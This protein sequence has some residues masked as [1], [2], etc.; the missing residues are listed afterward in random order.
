MS[1]NVTEQP[2]EALPVENQVNEFDDELEE[3]DPSM[4]DAYDIVFAQITDIMADGMVDESNVVWIIKAVM[5][6]IDAVA[7]FAEWPGPVK[8]Q[9][10]KLLAKHIIK[11]L[12]EKGKVDDET[13]KK[14]MSALSILSLAMFTLSVLGDKGKILFQHV[15]NGVQRA[16]IR[17]KNRQAEQLVQDKRIKK[18]RADLRNQAK[19]AHKAQCECGHHNEKKQ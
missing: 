16:C 7:V 11:D 10:S 18:G 14:L 15:K 2:M 12:H 13:Y 9:K 5:E 19:A 4:K 3:M 6:A 8:A 17:C 1:D